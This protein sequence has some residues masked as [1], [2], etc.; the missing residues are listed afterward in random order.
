MMPY[1]SIS[2]HFIIITAMLING[3]TRGHRR[4]HDAKRYTAPPSLVTAPHPVLCGGDGNKF[5]HTL[6]SIRMPFK[7]HIMQYIFHHSTLSPADDS[8][9]G[10]LLL[11]DTIRTV[12]TC[13]HSNYII[14]KSEQLIMRRTSFVAFVAF[15]AGTWCVNDGWRCR[16]AG[17]SAVHATTARTH[18]H[19]CASVMLGGR[20][21]QRLRQLV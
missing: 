21:A 20:P 17:V 8:A 11:T 10:A 19:A 4:R 18:T 1:N 5:A 7:M 12:H 2:T 16:R 14:F 6:T 15:V 9:L 3:Q 13:V